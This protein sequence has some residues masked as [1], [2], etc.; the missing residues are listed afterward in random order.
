MKLVPLIPFQ[1]EALTSYLRRLAW[2]HTLSPSALVRLAILEPIR[3]GRQQRQHVF[4]PT[5][6]SESLNGPTATAAGVVRQLAL[7]ARVALTPTTFINRDAAVSLHEAFR[8]F[9]AWCPRCLDCDETEAHDLLAWTLLAA[10][11][12]PVDGATLTDRCGR[13]GKQHRPLAA[14]ASPGHCPHCG[15]RLACAMGPALSQQELRRAE[16]VDG[17]VRWL[18]RVPSVSQAVVA[19]GISSAIAHVGGL[20]RSA[21][22]IPVSPSELSALRSG[23]VRPRI[24]T[25][26]DLILLSARSA[27][28]FLAQAPIPVASAAIR[29]RGASPR[30]DLAAGLRQAL[31]ELRPP[32]LRALAL[33]LGTTPRRLRTA[34]PDFSGQLLDRRRQAHHAAMAQRADKIRAEL[35]VAGAAI[36]ASGGLRTRRALERGMAKPGALRAAWVRDLVNEARG[37]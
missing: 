20:R 35:T 24:A 27:D 16:A 15:A 23:R 13:C 10:S 19:A 33:D 1:D 18:I 8:E 34:Y 14:W 4:Q 2:W 29:C 6:A 3:E 12:C 7:T 25:L 31:L 22:L 26:A 5:R 9:R 30:A 21:A 28:E 17:I 36:D 11:L 37:G 32:S